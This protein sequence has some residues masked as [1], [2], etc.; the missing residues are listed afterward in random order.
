MRQAAAFRTTGAG[1]ATLPMASLYASSTGGLWV[2]E[3]GVTNTTVTDFEVSLKRV[4]SAG[5]Q[6]TSQTVVYEENDANFTAKGDARDTHTV[7]PTLVNGELRRAYVGAS[8]GSGVIWTFGGRGLFVPSGVA[9]GIV[10]MPIVGTG[11]I[12]DVY[13]SWDA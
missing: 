10:L 8:K 1:S 9:N 3:I 13:F 12:C 2:V 5:T 7:A 4:T 6:G 11:Q